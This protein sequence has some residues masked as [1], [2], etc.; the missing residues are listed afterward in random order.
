M[1]VAALVI[2]ENVLIAFDRDD[3]GSVVLDAHSFRVNEL[4]IFTQL[5]VS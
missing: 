5:I 2:N 3:V 1:G 4:R